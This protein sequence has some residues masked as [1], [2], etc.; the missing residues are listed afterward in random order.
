MQAIDIFNKYALEYHNNFYNLLNSINIANLS[1][2]EL[3][4][5]IGN[6]KG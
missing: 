4:C 1:I 2:P 3:A 5:G 6:L